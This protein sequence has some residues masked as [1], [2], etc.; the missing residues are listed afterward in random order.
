[1]SCR[2][3]KPAAPIGPRARDHDAC[4]SAR[5]G[6][7]ARSGHHH[8]AATAIRIALRLH[9]R[10]PDCAPGCRENAPASPRLA[11]TRGHRNSGAR[12]Q[13]DLT[14]AGPCD[15]PADVLA[16]SWSF[17]VTSQV[18]RRPKLRSGNRAG[19]RRHDL[20]GCRAVVTTGNERASGGA[21][22]WPV[23]A[24]RAGEA[25]SR[26]APDVHPFAPV[27]DG[28]ETRSPTQ[29]TPIY[30]LLER[31]ALA[32]RTTRPIARASGFIVRLRSQLRNRS[33]KCPRARVGSPNGRNRAPGN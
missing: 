8:P 17:R 15:A 9:D 16:P 4:A 29:R 33:R 23:A 18:D 24:R 11:G 12:W 7:A 31:P 30:R 26:S 28:I 6:N 20:L 1:M 2:D 19:A 10:C 25:R 5:T 14:A 3:M 32:V 21:V 13:R 27:G 22:S